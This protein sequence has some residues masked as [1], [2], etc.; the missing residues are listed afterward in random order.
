MCPVGDGGCDFRLHWNQRRIH[1]CACAVLPDFDGDAGGIRFAGRKR[2]FQFSVIV[3]VDRAVAVCAEDRSSRAVGRK[4]KNPELHR[5]RIVVADDSL[6]DW[7]LGAC[8]LKVGEDECAWSVLRRLHRVEFI[9]G[10]LLFDKIWHSIVIPVGDRCRLR[11]R[12]QQNQ[13]EQDPKKGEGDPLRGAIHKQ[14]L[15][16]HEFSGDYY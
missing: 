15:L 16:N 14:L 12:G 2:D 1:E 5:G 4:G 7:D 9:G 11:C 13:S 6:C 10:L 8:L 3:V